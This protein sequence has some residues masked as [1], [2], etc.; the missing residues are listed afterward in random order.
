[1]AKQEYIRVLKVPPLNYTRKYANKV[2]IVTNRYDNND[3][4]GEM[5]AV[6]MNNEIRNFHKWHTESI[7]KKEYFVGALGG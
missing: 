6:I 2:G 4:N 3:G 1:M 5:V 7:T